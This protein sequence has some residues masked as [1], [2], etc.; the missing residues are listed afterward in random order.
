MWPTTTAC[1][2][3]I[4]FIVSRVSYELNA[5]QGWTCTRRNIGARGWIGKRGQEKQSV[6][7]R[8]EE[9]VSLFLDLLKRKRARGYLPRTVL[10]HM[11]SWPGPPVFFR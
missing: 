8:E 5:R 4:G 7:Q 1:I 6:F 10:R 3:A 11:Q 9:A 2:S